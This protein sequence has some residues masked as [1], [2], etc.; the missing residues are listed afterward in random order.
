MRP[1][2]TQNVKHKILKA[3]VISF[4]I[5][6]TLLVRPYL[7][8]TDLFL[9]MEKHYNRQFF[10]DCRISAE[11]DARED[12][13]A[14]DI[15]LDEI[16]NHI[17]DNFKDLK[18]KEL[19]WERMVLRANP[20][21]KDIYDF[22][23]KNGK[24]IVIASDMYLPSRFIADILHKNGYKGY[25]KLYV[26]GEIGATKCEGTM[27]DLIIK[28]M[29]VKPEK[30]LHIGDNN[31]SDY[32]KPR[33]YGL[34]AIHYPGISQYFEKN[35]ER[36]ARFCEKTKNDLG[37]SI[38]ASIMAY[39]NLIKKDDKYWDNLGYEY[40]GPVIYGYTRF[41]EKKSHEQGINNLLFVARDGYTLERVFNTFNND[42]TN[43][44]IYAPRLLN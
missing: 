11:Q 42:I 36:I 26:S 4:D 2:L 43:S 5:F 32:K 30:I 10:R 37:A 27:F 24:R 7:N 28:D 16:Y 40:A 35:N 33:K 34:C 38:L 44:Y 19:E 41:I 39:H 20:Q 25:E 22:A 31:N 18:Q 23:L 1:F 15:T 3:S 12:T 21:I 6:D 14:P 17:D 13:D 8:P 29:G 9:H